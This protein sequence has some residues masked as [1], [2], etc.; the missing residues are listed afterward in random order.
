[1]TFGRV[2]IFI[3]TWC[4]RNSELSL[5]LE[6]ND[7][8][9][10]SVLVCVINLQWEWTSSIWSVQM[11]FVLT[12]LFLFLFRCSEQV[13]RSISMNHFVFILEEE[14]E[15]KRKISWHI[16]F[17]SSPIDVIYDRLNL[18]SLFFLSFSTLSHWSLTFLFLNV[19]I[20]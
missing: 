14:R 11:M 4:N 7:L 2:S 1:M 20:D 15:R 10:M 17:L 18:A 12:H 19:N 9:L 8:S 5:S 16:F 6:T 3:R 13:R